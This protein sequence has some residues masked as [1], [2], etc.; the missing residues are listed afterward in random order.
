MNEVLCKSTYC[1][2]M[3]SKDNKPALKESFTHTVL[4]PDLL[5]IYRYQA[6]AYMIF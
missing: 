6:V 3:N 2:K 1:L 5:Y 4:I